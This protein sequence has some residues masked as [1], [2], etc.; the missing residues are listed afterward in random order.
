MPRDCTAPPC[1]GLLDEQSG[2]HVA[3][4]NTNM[5]RNKNKK[6]IG[7]KKKKSRTLR[8]ARPMNTPSVDRGTFT[9]GGVPAAYGAVTGTKQILPLQAGVGRK[10]LVQ[11]FELCHTAN[12]SNGA[13]SA[14]GDCANPGLSASYP[15]LSGIAKQYS[16]FRWHF[17]RYLYVPT[18]STTT[19]GSVF[20]TWVYDYQDAG[21]TSLAQVAQSSESSIGNAWFGGAI[22]PELAFS[23]EL[24]SRE[25][26]FVDMDVKRANDAWY[27]VRTSQAGVSPSTGG[28]LTGVIPA[29]LTFANG[30]FPDS[31]ARP[32]TIY[33]GADSVA[34]AAGIGNLF[35]SYICEFA[36]PVAPAM[37]V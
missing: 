28:M 20:F 4:S 36:D 19:A 10:L 25:A 23:R 16:K 2:C 3:G 34:G 21:P 7:R 12:G 31:E 27:Y 14:G 18:C 29:G 13:F 6:L 35:A 17:L 24:T 11:N 8:I 1:M 26:I 33:Y 32:G 5:A 15:W 30:T 37:N 9:L 22:N